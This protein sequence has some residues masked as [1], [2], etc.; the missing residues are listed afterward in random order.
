MDSQGRGIVLDILAFTSHYRESY[1]TLRGS[2][3]GE[4]AGEEDDG[5]CDDEKVARR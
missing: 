1:K 3:R 5:E 2:S 4:L